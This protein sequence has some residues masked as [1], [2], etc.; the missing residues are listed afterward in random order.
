MKKLNKKTRNTVN[1]IEAY[2]CSCPNYGCSCSVSNTTTEYYNNL[3][4]NIWAV[5]RHGS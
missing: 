3:W 2:T 1:T 5:Q 4:N